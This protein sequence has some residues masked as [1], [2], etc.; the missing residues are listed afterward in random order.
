MVKERDKYKLAN[1]IKIHKSLDHPNIVKF[2]RFFEDPEH[3][4][5]LLELC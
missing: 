1:E 4:Y 3:V 5:V 2:C